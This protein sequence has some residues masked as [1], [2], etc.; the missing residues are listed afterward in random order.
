MNTFSGYTAFPKAASPELLPQDDQQCASFLMTLLPLYAQHERSF[1]RGTSIHGR[2]HIIR[3]WIFSAAMSA[4]LNE[5]GLK[6]DRAALLCAVAG[7]DAGRRGNG[8]DI[9]EK[10]SAEITVRYM[11][12]SF[13]EKALGSAYERALR[14]CIEHDSVKRNN[15]LSLEAMLLHAADSLDIGRVVNFDPGQFPF[16]QGP[17]KRVCPGDAGQIRNQLAK[18]ASCLQRLT[19]PPVAEGPIRNVSLELRKELELEGQELM[20]RIEEVISENSKYFPLLSSYYS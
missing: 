14:D 10:Q 17:E 7:H 12:A 8:V 1:E 20:N 13:G 15:G 4:M 6:H 3:T 11:R 5:W 18:E 16:L 19:Y 9:W 2:G